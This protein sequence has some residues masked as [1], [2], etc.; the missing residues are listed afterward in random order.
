MMIIECINNDGFEDFLT[1]GADY[2]VRAIGA[3]GYQ[4]ETDQEGRVEWFGE[5]KFRLK[6]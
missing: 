5:S 2:R 4:I 1:A 6:L 3:N